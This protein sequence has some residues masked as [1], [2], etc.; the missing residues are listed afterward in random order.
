MRS[1]TNAVET[2]LIVLTSVLVGVTLARPLVGA[3]R[4]S[5][6]LPPGVVLMAFDPVARDD[7]SLSDEMPAAGAAFDQM[8]IRKGLL[9]RGQLDLFRHGIRSFAVVT[10]M[11][12][13]GGR[14]EDYREVELDLMVK[15]PGG[16]QF[17]AHETAFVPMTSLELVSPGNLIDTY[18]RPPDES[19]VAVHVPPS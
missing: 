11:Q 13:T 15:K 1:M 16:G 10:A 2:A 18:Y 3:R 12:T 4:D 17:P 6:V 7:P 19:T 8:L 5:V 9:T 14:R